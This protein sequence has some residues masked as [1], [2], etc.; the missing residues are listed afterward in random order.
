MPSNK[1]IVEVTEIAADQKVVRQAAHRLIDEAVSMYPPGQ[2]FTAEQL[3]RVI[4]VQT[5][6]ARRF[7]KLETLLLPSV[8]GLCGVEVAD[9]KRGTYYVCEGC[10][11]MLCSKCVVVD[12]LDHKNTPIRSW[13]SHEC[14]DAH[15]V[16][17][18]LKRGND[19]YFEWGDYGD[20]DHPP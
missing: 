10:G 6:N 13:C 18:A 2:A 11:D 16:E 3:K 15:Q 1:H 8:C 4:D 9:D 12:G 17:E 14:R 7:G 19:E 5:R 20:E